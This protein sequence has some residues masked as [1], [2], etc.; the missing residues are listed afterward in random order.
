MNT[1]QFYSESKKG[2]E[3]INFES[4]DG[5]NTGICHNR[6]Q[7]GKPCFFVSFD[8]IKSGKIETHY[9]FFSF[10]FMSESLF[11]KLLKAKNA[12]ELIDEK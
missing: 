11:Q 1:L 6:I 4:I 9:H 10:R 7:Q 12:Y 5:I 2:I 3:T 8:T